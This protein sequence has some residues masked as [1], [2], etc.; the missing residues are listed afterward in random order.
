M[1]DPPRPAKSAE[2]PYVAVF[3]R[4]DYYVHGWDKLRRAAVT[5][6]VDCGVSPADAEEQVASPADALYALF[7]TRPNAGNEPGAEA[8]VEYLA[9]VPMEQGG[10]VLL[11]D[12]PWAP[13]FGPEQED[14]ARQ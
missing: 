8:R 3:L 14:G 9:A 11:E 12:S 13:L 6:L 5:A 4:F 2:K 1:T 7:E 10:P